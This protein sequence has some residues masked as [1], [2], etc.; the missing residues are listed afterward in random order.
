MPTNVKVIRHSD[1]LR[2]RPDGQA[3]LE[4]GKAMLAEIAAAAVSLDQF[5]VLIDMRNVSGT[6]SP[7]DLYELA[8]SL[9][10]Y[11]DTFMHKTAVLC[12]RER[13]DHVRFF[14]LIAASHGFMR[15]RAFL[16]YEDAME[17]LLA[18]PDN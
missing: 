1:F 10:R 12:P 11:R 5:E 15:I 8:S 3:D 2:A 9:L 18:P 14:G 7:S 17:W 16:S 4:A 6:L 13:F